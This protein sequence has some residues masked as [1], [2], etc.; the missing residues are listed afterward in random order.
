MFEFSVG[1]SKRK[2][3]APNL[4]FVSPY[5]LEDCVWQLQNFPGV[6]EWFPV[7][8][9]VE[10]AQVDEETW[11]FRI[12]KSYLSLGFLNLGGN[13]RSRNQSDGGLGYPK[14]LVQGQLR[15]TLINTTFVVG[16]VT[17]SRGLGI[18]NLIL[19]CIIIGILMSGV[20]FAFNATPL[21][22]LLLVL[23]LAISVIISLFKSP[24]SDR[25]F[26]NAM[27]GHIK[28]VLGN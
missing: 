6:G 28:G 18:S 2:K 10:L 1:K 19:A 8:T 3:A 13:S 14:V 4:E 25:R 9:R 16:T 27:K 21:I 17:V 15:A 24:E 7:R 11:A 20:S 26:A 23:V 12:T 22:I 5:P